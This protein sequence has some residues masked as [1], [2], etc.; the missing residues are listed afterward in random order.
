MTSPGDEPPQA[1]HRGVRGQHHELAPR[2]CLLE[3]AVERAL[4]IGHDL[5][6]ATVEPAVGEAQRELRGAPTRDDHSIEGGEEGLEVDVP[7]PG[8]VTAVG[9]LVVERND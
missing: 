6:P 1:E 3:A 2:G 8:D 9:D 4:E 5:D 7:D